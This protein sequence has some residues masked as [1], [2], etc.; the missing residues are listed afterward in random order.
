MLATTTL[1]ELRAEADH[2]LADGVELRRRI[3]RRPELGLDLPETQAAVLDALHGLPLDLATGTSSTS[4]V[5]VLHGAEPGPAIVLRGDMDAL[6]LQEDTG[7]DFA[8]EIDGRMH[9]CGHDSHT[10]MLA[11]AMRV[12]AGRRDEF[13]G[14]VIAMFQPGE[15]GFFGARAMIREGLLDTPDGSADPTITRAFAIHVTPS[16]PSGWIVSRPGTL[17]AS[18]DDFHVVIRGAGG[19]GS[20]PHHAIDPVPVAC[21]AVVA[22]QTA[23]T[24]QIDIFDPAVLTVG[25]LR[26]GTTTNVIPETARFSGTIRTTTPKAREKVRRVF[27]QVVEGVAKAHGATAEIDYEVGYSV[28]SNHPGP[29]D[30]VASVASELLGSDKVFIPVPNPVMGGEDFGEVLE[31]VPGSM[32]FLGVCPPDLDP[33]TAPANHSNLMRMDESAMASGIAL[34]AAVALDHLQSA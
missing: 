4:V 5:A 1:Q 6:P 27:H 20:M 2:A 8:S 18:T 10:A 15:E 17:L 22:L 26:A 3:H 31:R 32:V 16:A 19:H 9:A 11:A 13:A 25:L 12:L 24:R 34:H 14:R 33:A 29:L 21:E 28:T 7:L 30:A 23:I